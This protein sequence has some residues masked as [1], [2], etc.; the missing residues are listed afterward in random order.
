MKGSTSRSGVVVIG[1]SLVDIIH[2]SAGAPSE[3]PGG[4]PLNVAVGCSRLGVSTSLVTT[5][6][7]GDRHGRLIDEHLSSNGVTV[8]NAG[9]T[10]TSTAAAILDS[11]GAATY[12][13]DLSWDIAAATDQANGAGTAA[14]HLHT[15]SIATVLAPGCHDVLALLEGARATASISFD[16][17]CRPMITP[18]VGAARQTVERF[19]ALS[20]IVKA[21]D[22]D[23]AWL[24]PDLPV[25]SV[26]EEWLRR[27]P[28][29]VVVTR[30]GHGP[31]AYSHASC[32][33]V[34][35]TVVSVVD[36]VGAGDSFMAALLAGLHEMGLLGA[37][38]RNGLAA[39]DDATLERLARYAAD[40]A[41]ITCSRPGA[42]PPT[43]SEFR[44][45]QAFG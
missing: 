36:T 3:L 39:L 28:G 17:N 43:S 20:D 42:D 8:L 35:A 32:V 4:S 21:S 18:D 2:T 40:A 10:V 11:S 38:N 19:V 5:Y 22:E 29:I 30:G 41:A 37:A 44:S 34:P 33:T 31:L 26:V 12:K 9:S 45:M 7:D 16:P 27:G 14:F 24:Y 23:L 1:E 25:E 15:G 6:A 13:F